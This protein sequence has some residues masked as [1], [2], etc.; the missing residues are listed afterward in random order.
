VLLAPAE[1]A[2]DHGAARLGYT[3]ARVP[4][5]CGHQLRFGGV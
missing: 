3:V 2:L 5:W 4:P 1:D